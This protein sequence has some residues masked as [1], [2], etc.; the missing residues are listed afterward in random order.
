[1]ALKIFDDIIALEDTK[2]HKQ[3]P[4]PI[5]EALRRVNG[6]KQEALM[7]GYSEFDIKC[8]YNAGVD[9]VFVSWSQAIDCQDISVEPVYIIKDIT[10][11]MNIIKMM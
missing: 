3:E 4:E 10:D 2:K 8:A 6:K 1:M 11:I 9:S 7:I 5:L